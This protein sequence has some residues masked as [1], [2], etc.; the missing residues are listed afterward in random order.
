M[1]CER[2]CCGADQ[3]FDLKNARKKIKHYK[4][5]GAIKTTKKMV[6]LLFLQDVKGK[7]LLDVGG[8][9]G[10]IQWEFL[11]NGGAK[12][13]DVDS[14]RAFLDVASSFADENQYSDKAKFLFGDLVDKH[15]EIVAA[16]FV[17]LD[18]VVCC[19]PDYKSLLDIALKKCNNTIVLSYPLAGWISE[20]VN[21]LSDFYLY[22][23]K[24]PFRSFVHPPKEIENF[25]ISRGFMPV[26]KQISFPWHVQVYQKVKATA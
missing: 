19:Y 20:F 11:K 12:T 4:K 3:F 6:D 24:N 15:D 14:S 17:T 21:F 16:D 13:Q 5:K 22:F 8:G 23:T 10:A 9:I 25:M 2:H 7:S 26:Q 18:K 1:T